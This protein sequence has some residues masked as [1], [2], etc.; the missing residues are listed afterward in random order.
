M[1][2]ISLLLVHIILLPAVHAAVSPPLRIHF[3]SGSKEYHSEDSLREFSASLETRG[4]VCT[5]SWGQDKGKTLPN[6]AALADADLMIVF[7]RRMDLPEE[8][9][10][11]IRAHWEKGKAIIGIRTASHAW[12]E[13]G[14]PDGA[15]FDHEILGNHYSGHYGD[16]PVQVS[17]VPGQENHPV[18]KGVEPFVSRKL[19]KNKGPAPD[20]IAL[21][22]GDNGRGR[23][24][25]TLVHEYNGGRAFYTSLGVPEDF[26]DRNFRRL[27]MNAIYWTTR[28]SPDHE[29]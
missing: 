23:E 18:L 1:K 12:G 3:I 15:Y 13:K 20:A 26:K 2:I 14:D 29:P 19:Y 27:L 22:T 17:A 24:V 21:Q 4:F 7:T 25:V 6:L 28:R 9:M 11:L 8:Q 5:A 10:E 16:E